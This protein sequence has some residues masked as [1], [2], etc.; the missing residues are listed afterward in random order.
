VA[1]TGNRAYPHWHNLYE[2]ALLESDL[3]KLP[4]RITEAQDAVMD[5]IIVLDG[6]NCGGSESEALMNALSVLR[7]FQKM[8]ES[9]HVARN[10][11]DAPMA[12]YRKHF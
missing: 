10:S 4:Q 11:G 12:L 3:D 2:A 8:A 1:N 6:R 9:V 5:R 7:D